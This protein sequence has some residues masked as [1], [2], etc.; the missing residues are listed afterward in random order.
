MWKR[1]W[2]YLSE[3]EAW[4]FIGILV[5][6]GVVSYFVFFSLF[7][8]TL[9]RH[10]DEY[11]LPSLV[12]RSY[13]SVVRSLETAGFSAVVIDSQYV[14]DKSPM[15]V[16]LQDP[17]PKT[18]IKRGRK[19]YLT[20]S[21]YVPPQVPLPRVQDLPYE[22][23]Y[24]LLKESYG[25]SIG[26]VIYVTGNVPDIVVEVR[27]Q[28]RAVPAGTPV[29]KYASLALVVSRGLS[30]QKVP[31]V[32]VVGLPVEQAV[33]KL[34]AVGLAVGHIRYKPAP[35]TPLGHV[36]RQ[37]P[38]RVPGDSL[39]MGMAIDLFVNSEPPKGASE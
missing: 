4:I 19:I 2:V 32:S 6:V 25:F 22:Q 9:T 37:Y 10:G 7:L 34:N 21:S 13:A 5:A 27:Y 8:P 38:D 11:L 18:R 3:R 33:A 35:N 20:V 31:F 29:P 15:T 28:G 39:P 24:R 23:A 36:Y 16:L 1:L 17:P 30:E 12:G 26:E 14:P